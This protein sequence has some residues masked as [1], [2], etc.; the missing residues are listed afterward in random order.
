MPN[1]VSDVLDERFRPSQFVYN[2]AGYGQVR[3]LVATAN[4]VDG[5]RLALV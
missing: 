3:A 4:V 5:P 1:S 2:H